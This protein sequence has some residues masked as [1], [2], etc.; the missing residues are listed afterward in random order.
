[1]RIITLINILFLCLSLLSCSSNLTKKNHML[2]QTKTMDCSLIQGCMQVYTGTN[3]NGTSRVFCF[4]PTNLT[5]FYLGTSTTETWN[6]QINSIKLA[7]QTKTNIYY[8]INYGGGYWTLINSSTSSCKS[9]RL[10]ATKASSI[11]LDGLTE[12]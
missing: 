1:M 12:I 10:S 9:A 8:D 11:K 6:D 2:L 3:L 7:P 5:K 4:S